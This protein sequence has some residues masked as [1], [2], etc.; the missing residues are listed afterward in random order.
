MKTHSAPITYERRGAQPPLELERVPPRVLDKPVVRLVEVVRSVPVD[1][2]VERVR[3]RAEVNYLFIYLYL[4]L[5]L[6]LLL[7]LLLSLNRW[8]EVK[9]IH[10][11][12]HIRAF[13]RA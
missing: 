4:L 6:S 1:K 12:A 3:E 2:V 7:L 13:Q 9:S 5:S 10:T 8:A 11:R